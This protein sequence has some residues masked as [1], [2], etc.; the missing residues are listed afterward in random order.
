MFFLQN[1]DVLVLLREQC[2][3]GRAG[4]PTANNKDIAFTSV[5]LAE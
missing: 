4:G 2:G 3:N 1:N 5:H